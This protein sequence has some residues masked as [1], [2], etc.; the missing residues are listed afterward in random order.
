MVAENWK[1]YWF[2]L[3]DQTVKLQLILFWQS[4]WLIQIITS[5]GHYSMYFEIFKNVLGGVFYKKNAE[6]YKI[7]FWVHQVHLSY[8]K[9]WYFDTVGH[10][11]VILY[12][13]TFLRIL[14]V[15]RRYNEHFQNGWS[16]LK[17]KYWFLLKDQVVMVQF[18]NFNR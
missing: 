9:S 12:Q 10:E 11:S 16:K 15:V 8:F 17:K 18:N 1:K 13:N 2:S 4:W 3:Q 14:I 5:E 6:N 7:L